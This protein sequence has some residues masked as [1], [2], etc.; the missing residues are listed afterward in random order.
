M[1]QILL[2]FVLLP[3][4]LIGGI[5]IHDF[6]LGAM[7]SH[8][9]SAKDSTDGMSRPTVHYHTHVHRMQLRMGRTVAAPDPRKH[10]MGGVKSKQDHGG[11]IDDAHRLMVPSLV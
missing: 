5:V 6:H 1:Q 9:V 2:S 3:Y 8:V 7:I 11:D 4:V 10:T